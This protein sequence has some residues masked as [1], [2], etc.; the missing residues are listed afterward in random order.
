MIMLLM[1]PFLLSCSTQDSEMPQSKPSSVIFITLDT[2]RQ[3][4]LG[5]YGYEQAK[6]PTIDKIASEGQIYE[7]SYATVPLT[8]P[9]HT[10][11]FTGLYPSRHGIHSN[12]D[13]ILAEELTTVTEILSQEGYRTAG[14]VSAFV[15][16][17]IWGFS[18]GFDAYF[19]RIEREHDNQRWRLE[20]NAQTVVDDLVSW[21]EDQ[22]S[23]Q[24]FFMWAHFYD[25]HHPHEV[26][27]DF[28][29]NFT[30]LYDAEISYVD[31]EIQ[32]LQEI[33]ENMVG[34]D[35]ITWVITADHGESFGEHQENGHG[36]FVWN[37]TMQV[38]LII[39]PSK[40]WKDRHPEFQSGHIDK[41]NTVSGIDIAPT[42]LALAGVTSQ[43]E[44]IDGLDISPTLEQKSLDRDF[45]YMESTQP[46]VRFGYHPEIAVVGRG[47]KLIETPSPHLY[48]VISDHEEKQNLLPQEKIP[49]QL[50]GK[51]KEI[52]Q[53]QPEVQSQSNINNQVVDQLAALGYISN[54][55]EQNELSN[56]D[57]KDKMETIVKIEYIRKLQKQSRDTPKK[58]AEIELII[59]QKYQEILQQEPQIAE[60]RIGLAA[61]Y[62]RQKKYNQAI[63]VYEM[64]LSL[65]PQSSVLR[66]NMANVY[67][68]MGEFSKGIDLLESLLEQVP[69][70]QQAQAGLLKMLIDN[71]SLAKALDLGKEY[72]KAAP[73]NR[74]LQALVGI[75]LFRSQ[76]L[77]IAHELLMASTQDDIPRQ[78]VFSSIAKL[79]IA[80]D[81]SEQGL[82]YFLQEYEHFPTADVARLI[83]NL[84][85]NQ[86]NYEQSSLYYKKSIEIAK[87][88][89]VRIQYAQALFNEK[90][91]KEAETALSP[92]YSPQSK[93]PNVLL[94]QANIFAKMDQYEKGQ[95]LFEKAKKLIEVQK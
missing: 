28:A 71:K 17:E 81:K 48:Q 85:S 84:Y 55:F 9:S 89:A 66:M 67:A 40:N 12:G 75:A 29:H 63:S 58:R 37:T 18:Q 60:A 54:D 87:N 34:A 79:S 26:P 41:I 77:S 56:V 43:L 10:S 51:G 95:K 16:T 15:T 59:E 80:Q 5:C 52:Y 68:E 21:L 1:F 30:D 82:N 3:D 83:G 33:A 61:L 13:A 22:S 39:K 4:R 44:N 91:Y 78:Y 46:Q 73:Q 23:D 31:R 65:Q 35:N 94:L 36:M 74:E 25:A 47:T 7:Q 76:Q 88:P 49:S 24:P 69:T 92:L 20:R 57:A 11:M 53:L 93:N 50:E 27:D 62:T 45:V 72:L 19:D 70:D 14:S 32:R 2:T 8:T 6:T 90:K 42:I 64:A 86:K 38:P